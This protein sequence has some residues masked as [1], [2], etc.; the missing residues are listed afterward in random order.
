MSKLNRVIFLWSV[1][2]VYLI[3]GFGLIG[4]DKGAYQMAGAMW[5][6]IGWVVPLLLYVETVDT[7]SKFR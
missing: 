3:V 6:F 7:L 2:V 5:F 4:S 1:A